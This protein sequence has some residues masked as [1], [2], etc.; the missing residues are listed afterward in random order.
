[1]M[2]RHSEFV[3][4]VAKA[5]EEARC[6]V[7]GLPH[8]S[9]L[10]ALGHQMCPE[11]LADK[12]GKP[13]TD[14]R[15][16]A[17]WRES[18][19]MAF[20]T[21]HSRIRRPLHP[22]AASGYCSS[23]FFFFPDLMH[24]MDCKGVSGIFMGSAIAILMQRRGLGSNRTQRLQA[25]NAHKAAWY[26]EHGEGI[27][28]RLPPLIPT[29]LV[30][31]GWAELT[32][33]VVKAAATRHAVPWCAALCRAHLTSGSE[34]DRVV[35]QMADDLVELYRILY[36]AGRFLTADEV[37]R[38]RD[39]CLSFG[40][41]FQY[42]REYSRLNSECWFNVKPKVHKMQHLP[43]M[44]EALNPRYV[45]NYSEESLIGT[46]TKIW[47][48]SVAGRYKRGVQRTVLAKKAVALLLGL[49]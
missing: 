34:E 48:R 49:H 9:G 28:S 22:L 47:A 32:G 26:T 36:S 25:I 20:S 11:C 39:V 24:L 21:F 44:A 45:Q 10:I 13:F 2:R 8:Y 4:L 18:E 40:R 23:K 30:L 43:M 35:I 6:T 3:L 12:S 41:G 17:K 33:T 15:A 27:T 5:D 46:S 42:M 7:F 16:G 1:M 31:D 29:S 19:D 38:L 14:L 37:R